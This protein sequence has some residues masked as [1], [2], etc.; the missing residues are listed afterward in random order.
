MQKLSLN[1]TLAILILNNKITITYFYFNIEIYRDF[2]P[3]LKN[4]I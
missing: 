4:T 1:I 3:I 2:F